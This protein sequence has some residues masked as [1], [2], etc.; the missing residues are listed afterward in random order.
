MAAMR[1]PMPCCVVR[2]IIFL[3]NRGEQNVAWNKLLFK[4]ECQYE[5]VKM[6]RDFHKPNDSAARLAVLSGVALTQD[7]P[8][9]ALIRHFAGMLSPDTRIVGASALRVSAL[10]S[11]MTF[12]RF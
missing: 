7:E 9:E 5:A 4:R 11:R 3:A 6:Q 10:S 2:S 12:M 1:L 8:V